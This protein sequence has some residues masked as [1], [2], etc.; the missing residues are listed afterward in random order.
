[1]TDDLVELGVR[2]EFYR[3]MWREAERPIEYVGS[4]VRDGFRALAVPRAGE[5]VGYIGPWTRETPYALV[6][7]VEHLVGADAGRVMVVVRAP[8]PGDGMTDQLLGTFAERGWRWIA[9]ESLDW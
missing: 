2:I 1:M 3:D 8:W 6:T 4:A 7:S 9:D 5:G